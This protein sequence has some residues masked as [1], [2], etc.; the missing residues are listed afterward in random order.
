MYVYYRVTG[1]GSAAAAAVAALLRDVEL[2][3]GVAGTLLR[4]RDDA[5]TWMEVFAPI[6]DVDAFL[7]SLAACEAGAGIAGVV[8]EGTRRRECFVPLDVA[9]P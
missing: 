4:R 5:S 7:L 3:T 9:A 6:A 2:A 1:A 8:D